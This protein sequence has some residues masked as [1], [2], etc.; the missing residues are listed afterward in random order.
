[1]SDQV[2]TLKKL[3]KKTP[4]C[5]PTRSARTTQ[6]AT[7]Q[8]PLL[9]R[10]PAGQAPPL[11]SAAAGGAP[12]KPAR[13]PPI[14]RQRAIE[15]RPGRTLTRAR[16]SSTTGGAA[17]GALVELLRRLLFTASS[18]SDQSGRR[19]RQSAIP[20]RWSRPLPERWRRPSPALGPGGAGTGGAGPRQR[21]A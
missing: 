18:S 2:K 3:K 5:L 11:T 19:R 10:L 14:E 7:G 21:P 15:I 1:M 20:A 8:D 12:T 6:T 17:P 9:A 13:R 4:H 16:W